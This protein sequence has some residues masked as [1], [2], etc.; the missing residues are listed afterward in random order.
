MKTIL[1]DFKEKFPTVWAKPGVDFSGDQ[2]ALIWSGE[3]SMIG[4]LPAFNYYSEG[5]CY[6][7]GVHK[8]LIKWADS[9]NAFWEWYDGGTIFLYKK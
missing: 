3:S 5:E 2:Y 1:E 7:M 9:H 8:D 4:D 6:D